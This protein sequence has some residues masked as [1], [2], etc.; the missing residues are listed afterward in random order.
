MT[1]IWKRHG[2]ASFLWHPLRR[3]GPL[4]GMLWPQRWLVPGP[5]NWWCWCLYLQ[6][7]NQFNQNH[8]LLG[9]H[10]L[11]NL[12][13]AIPTTKACSLFGR[14]ICTTCSGED[15]GGPLDFKSARVKF[16]IFI[17]FHRSNMVFSEILSLFKTRTSKDV[18]LLA[19]QEMCIRHI[20]RSW[21]E[22]SWSHWPQLRK[23]PVLRERICSQKRTQ[24]LVLQFLVALP[25]NSRIIKIIDVCK[26][27]QC[28]VV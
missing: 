20:G 19:V 2:G 7:F 17:Y 23:R 6:V 22:K 24:K 5:T 1:A 26:V 13:W 4:G 27:K 15:I 25:V 12:I 21:K 3:L 8:L 16:L 28:S 11:Y 14:C 9:L 10:Q 18:E